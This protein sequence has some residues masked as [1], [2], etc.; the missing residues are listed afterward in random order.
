MFC[1]LQVPKNAVAKKFL[2]RFSILGI[3]E[4]PHKMDR[5]F[6][7]VGD[8]AGSVMMAITPSI[9]VSPT[10]VELEKPVTIQLPSC[11]AVYSS[12]HQPETDE[13]QPQNEGG[14]KTGSNAFGVKRMG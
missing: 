9:N 8:N 6:S 13:D 11:I 14:G 12:N 1:R 7:R 10:D 4:T 5:I 2:L 3:S